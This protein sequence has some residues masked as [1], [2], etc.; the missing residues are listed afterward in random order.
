MDKL[1]TIKY[2]KFAF[3]IIFQL[4]VMHYLLRITRITDQR[5]FDFNF[6]CHQHL[7]WTGSILN[8]EPVVMNSTS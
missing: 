7:L 3:T 5:F 4:I 8:K 2:I 6:L 1:T